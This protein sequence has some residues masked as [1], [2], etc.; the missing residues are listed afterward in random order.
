MPLFFRS[1]PLSSY[2]SPSFTGYLLPSG[3][4]CT[5][6]KLKMDAEVRIVVVVIVVVVRQPEAARPQHCNAPPCLFIYE[7]LYTILGSFLP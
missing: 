2:H 5:T 4:V 3:K 7:V 6:E 1:A